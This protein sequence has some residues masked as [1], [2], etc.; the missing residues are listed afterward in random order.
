MH[1]I[2]AA[3]SGSYFSKVVETWKTERWRLPG[4]HITIFLLW[5]LIQ[6][7]V[8]FFLALPIDGSAG[9]WMM[10][11]L[12]HFYGIYQILVQRKHAFNFLS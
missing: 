10:I 7:K 12:L 11:L 3:S 8:F 5:V 2:M 4:R 9:L 6:R 1:I